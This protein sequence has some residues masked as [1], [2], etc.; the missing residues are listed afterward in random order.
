MTAHQDPL[1]CTHGH[2]ASEI[3]LEDG[4]VQRVAELCKL[5]CAEGYGAPYVH[6]VSPFEKPDLCVVCKKKMSDTEA[7]FQLHHPAEQA[8]FP[9]GE[10]LPEHPG[11]DSTPK[12][13]VRVDAEGW[14][15]EGAVAF[16]PKCLRVQEGTIAWG[17]MHAKACDWRPKTAPAAA[18]SS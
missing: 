1:R 5:G 17:L 16:C 9:C 12:R 7:R 3:E 10:K 8:C 13:R 15:L 11:S 14:L 18:A 2:F 6:G 4:R